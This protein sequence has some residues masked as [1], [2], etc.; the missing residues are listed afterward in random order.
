MKK[1]EGKIWPIL[2][3]LGKNW[4]V[5]VPIIVSLVALG[6]SLCS[7]KIA[8]D[9]NRIAKETNEMS[10]YQFLQLNRPFI[11][12]SSKIFD[13]EQFWQIK[14]EGKIIKIVFKY[15][16]KNAGNIIAKDIAFPD[17]VGLI[18]GTKIK[19][20]S[21]VHVDTYGELTIGPGASINIDQGLALDCENE[22]NAKKY[23]EDL[24]S[25]K[26]PGIDVP[27]WVNYTNELD[28]TKRYKTFVKYKFYKNATVL[29]KSEMETLSDENLTK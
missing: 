3:W 25:D 28:E 12:L 24:I 10:N 16:L 5:C 2:L 9:A 11:I 8:S 1:E 6:I 20:Y 19:K 22:E 7:N 13:N 27:I 26:S 15:K 29:I 4:K 18:S 14:Q 21:Q 17:K 23:Y